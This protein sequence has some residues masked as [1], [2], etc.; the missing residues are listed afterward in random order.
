LSSGFYTCPVMC[1]PS[2]QTPHIHTHTH[3][4]IH[5]MHLMCI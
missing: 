4:H 3:T 1:A 2:L 5:T